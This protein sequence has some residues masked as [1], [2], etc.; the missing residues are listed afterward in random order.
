M[1][2]AILVIR[3]DVGY[4]HSFVIE[5]PN[6]DDL[7]MLQNMNGKE[8]EDELNDANPHAIR[9][10]NLIDYKIDSSSSVTN[11]MDEDWSQLILDLTAEPASVELESPTT[12]VTLYQVCVA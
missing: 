1:S 2:T 8:L 10:A 9:L 5:Q 11:E 3:Y 7:G 12:K 4:T 6:E